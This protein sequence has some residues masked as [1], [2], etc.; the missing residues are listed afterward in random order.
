M[1]PR[2]AVVQHTPQWQR[3]LAQAI[4]DPRVLLQLLELDHLLAPAR[5]AAARQFPL[6]VPREF[7][8]RM[9]VGD[10]DDPLLRQVLPIDSEGY[11]P[12]DY[13]A[14]PLQEQ[15]AMPTP[16]LL[17][18]YAGRVLLTLTGACGIHCRYCFRR[19]FP[20]SE[21]N[22]T[23]QHWDAALDYI[24]RHED[25]HEVL[26]SGGDPLS[27]SDRRL[28]TL[29]QSLDEIPHLQRL[30]IHTRLVVV[31]PS[32][33]DAALLEWLGNSRLHQV[34][35]I[36]TNHAQELSSSVDAALARLRNQGVQ[37]LNQAVLLRGVNDCVD[38]Q[39]ALSERLLASGVIPYYLHLLDRVAG[40]AHFEVPESEAIA[41]L[42]ALQA[43]LPGYLV[44]RLAREEP[45]AHS[46]TWL[47][48]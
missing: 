43:R 36:H 20:Y 22:P 1:I 35:V 37:L 41:L 9:T 47:L 7:I 38:A 30:R 11:S 14:D 19:H 24:R 6:R 26:L 8:Q 17:H 10:P 13:G 33:V 21:A 3:E 18:K 29:V 31:L 2:T 4:Q 40:A 5:H 15:G 16:G 48:P 28:A 12:Q 39:V 27:L 45:G 42:R 25:I 34:M 32:R 44:P 23:Q 46:K